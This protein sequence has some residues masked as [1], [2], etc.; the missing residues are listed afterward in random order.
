MDNNIINPPPYPSSYRDRITYHDY[1][2]MIEDTHYEKYLEFIRPHIINEDRYRSL[3]RELRMEH[4]LHRN[5]LI[6]LKG[7]FPDFI[8]VELIH[9]WLPFREASDSHWIGNTMIRLH[10]DMML[11]VLTHLRAR[12]LAIKLNEETWE[13]MKHKQAML[14]L[15]SEFVYDP[16]YYYL[17]I[18]HVNEL[19]LRLT[20]EGY[21]TTAIDIMKF[22]GKVDRLF[23]YIDSE[24]L[25][26][27]DIEKEAK[28]D[29]LPILLSK[30]VKYCRVQLLCFS[31]SFSILPFVE[32][33][34]VLLDRL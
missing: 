6:K 32:L 34:F 33:D 18:A 25:N 10:P 23:I 5:V 1:N 24:T 2:P 27:P 15:F 9:S 7:T 3:Y 29:L 13:I 30:E 11:F 21:L 12:F 20:L 22:I 8:D 28:K 4:P 17:S 26:V 31:K 19:G 16:V 14:K